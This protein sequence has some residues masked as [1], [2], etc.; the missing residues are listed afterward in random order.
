MR[1]NKLY[2]VLGML[3][4]LAFLGGP[5]ARAGVTD[6]ATTITFSAPIEIP[7]HALPPG[8]Y[9]FKLADDG[10]YPNVVQIFNSD[11]TKLYASV[12]TIPTEMQR[13]PDNTA[14]TLAEQGSG[15]PDAL[16]KWFYP[17]CQT[18]HEFMYSAQEDKELTQDK[19]QTI[20]VNPNSD[21][22]AGD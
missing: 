8:T 17:G 11:G 2:I 4:A 5:V 22:Y 9:L 14:I 19:Q 1:T 20:V 15:A 16:L 21:T 13:P 10:A 12:Q 6:E 3:V 7:G 18:G